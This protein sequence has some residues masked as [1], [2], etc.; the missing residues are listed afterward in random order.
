MYTLNTYLSQDDV[1]TDDVKCNCSTALSGT[2][3]DDCFSI[4]VEPSHGFECIEFERAM[5]FQL[6]GCGRS[7]LPIRSRWNLT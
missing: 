3:T 2:F 5:I 7:E 1:I 6:D 4:P